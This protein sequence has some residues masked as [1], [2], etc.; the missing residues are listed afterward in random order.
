MAVFISVSNKKNVSKLRYLILWSVATTLVALLFF[1]PYFDHWRCERI[2]SEIEQQYGLT[3]RY[4]GP[5]GFHV[6][7]LPATS[8]DP[9]EGYFIGPS[10]ERFVVAALKGVR[11]ALSKYPKVLI[12]KYLTAVFVPGK[13]TINCVEGSGTYLH[14]WIYLA[15][16]KEHKRIDAD[17][18]AQ[19]F[20]HEL[21]SLFLKGANFPKIRWHLAN[22]PGFKYLPSQIDVVHAASPENRRNPEEAP[23]WY[24]AGFVHYYGMSSMENDFN[25]YAE[26]AMTHP[27][28]LKELADKYPRILAKTWVLVDFYSRLAP[29]LKEYLASAGLTKLP[30]LKQAHQEQQ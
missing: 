15:A 7:P 17:V 29:E 10:R 8:N 28:K 23:T 1:L 27:E 24:Q 11:K 19:T 21:S 25:M 9:E 5:S 3:V 2:A 12:R 14:S 22:E 20:H 6:P 26:L 30:G 18:Y 16:K 4:G 13:I